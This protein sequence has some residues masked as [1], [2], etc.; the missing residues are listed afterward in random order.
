MRVPLYLRT[1]HFCDACGDQ[2]SAQLITGPCR[3]V[4]DTED[5]HFIFRGTLLG[6]LGQPMPQDQIL[7]QDQQQQLGLEGQAE[8]AGQT[9][10]AVYYQ[11]DSLK[12]SAEGGDPLAA[13]ILGACLCRGLGVHGAELS[14]C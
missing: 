5:A 7:A 9:I 8:P 12:A 11:I 4:Q 10:P 13:N 14:A 3:A 6:V 2:Q 1:V